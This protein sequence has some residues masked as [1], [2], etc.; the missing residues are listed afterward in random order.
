MLV[1]DGG[2]QLNNTSILY[3]PDGSYAGCVATV[4]EALL[5]QTVNLCHWH[6][7]EFNYTSAA[8]SHCTEYFP[9][10]VIVI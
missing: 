1:L 6:S 10:T 9:T 4:L 7:M 3:S 5:H 2:E 8:L